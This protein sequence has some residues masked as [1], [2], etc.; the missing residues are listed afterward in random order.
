MCC[1]KRK[2]ETKK[3]DENDKKEKGHKMDTGM[4]YKLD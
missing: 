4:I 1:V 3:E 2:R